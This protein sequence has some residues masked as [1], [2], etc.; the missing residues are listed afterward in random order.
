M[1][2]PTVK[3]VIRFLILQQDVVAKFEGFRLKFL[4][5]GELFSQGH[6]EQIQG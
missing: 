6:W 3:Y 5:P 1:T 4:K 2:C